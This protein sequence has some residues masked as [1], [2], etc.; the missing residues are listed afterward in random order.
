M[1]KLSSLTQSKS[2]FSWLTKGRKK[3]EKE[4]ERKRGEKK[5]EKAGRRRITSDWQ[6][7][8]CSPLSTLSLSLSL[9][10]MVIG[11]WVTGQAARE[12]LKLKSK[13]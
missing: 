13:K 3:K 4:E 6:P 9:S 5:K 7:P 12:G 10:L 8:L 2:S 1:A 11:K